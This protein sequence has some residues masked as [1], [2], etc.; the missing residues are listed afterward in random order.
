MIL[1][2]KAA[3]LG[4][5]DECKRLHATCIATGVA[6]P[7]A[8]ADD[9]LALRAAAKHGHLA[10][11]EWL[12]VTYFHT[13]GNTD[14]RADDNAALHWAAYSRDQTLRQFGGVYRSPDCSEITRS[15]LSQMPI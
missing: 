10:V 12:R 2:V 9:N 3:Q 13:C 7:D 5:L 15:F 6:I 1:L 11:C 4:S 14:A 8:R